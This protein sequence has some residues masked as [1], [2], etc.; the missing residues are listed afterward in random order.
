MPRVVPDQR[1]KFENDELFRK[2][3]RESEVSGCTNCTNWHGDV[4]WITLERAPMRSYVKLLWPL[5]IIML[6]QYGSAA[7][8]CSFFPQHHGQR[9]NCRCKHNFVCRLA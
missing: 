4:C 9:V 7:R 3:S 8:K 5:D 2:M 6:V 1:E